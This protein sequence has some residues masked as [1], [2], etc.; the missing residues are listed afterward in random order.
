MAKLIAGVVPPLE[1]IGDVPVT[2]V[3]VPV[4]F[5]AVVDIVNLESLV[6]ATE[7]RPA[8]TNSISS[9]VESLPANLNLVVEFGIETV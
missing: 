8:P 9:E 4:L 5:V 2:Q 7:I 3:T 6:R 1:V